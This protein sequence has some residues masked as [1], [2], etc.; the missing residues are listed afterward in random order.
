MNFKFCFSFLLLGSIFSFTSCDENR[1]FD[2][3]YD[4]EQKV[5][6]NDTVPSFEFEISDTDQTYNLLWNVRNTID[7]PYRNL[8]VTYYL[9]DTLGRRLST[10][11]HNMMLFDS[12]SGKPY[13]SGMGDIFSHQIMALPGYRFDTA[14]VYRIRLEQYMRTDS[15]KNILSI[16]VRVEEN[17]E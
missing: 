9:E 1:V 16:G 14:G 11:L 3:N 4:F 15:L 2:E 12:K 13:G 17:I 7:F 5:W 6:L 10:D 8:Y